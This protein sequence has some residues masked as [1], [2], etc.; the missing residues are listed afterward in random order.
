MGTCTKLSKIFVHLSENSLPW[1]TVAGKEELFT[2]EFLKQL[3]FSEETLSSD[4]FKGALGSPEFRGRLLVM[5]AFY[6][7]AARL[8]VST[9]WEP[10][11]EKCTEWFFDINKQSLQEINQQFCNF[12]K[13][14]LAGKI[15]DSDQIKP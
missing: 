9:P 15:K 10:P 12:I 5:L 6:Q 11:S 1:K 8:N 2:S 4:M 7:V 3:S 14:E 13:S